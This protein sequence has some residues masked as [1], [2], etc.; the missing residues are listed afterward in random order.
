MRLHPRRKDTRGSQWVSPEDHAR[1]RSLESVPGKTV[2]Q[3]T[4]RQSVHLIACTDELPAR[5]GRGLRPVT[6][7]LN[8]TDIVE[9]VWRSSTHCNAGMMRERDGHP[10]QMPPSQSRVQAQSPADHTRSGAQRSRGPPWPPGVAQTASL[11]D[12]RQAYLFHARI[13]ICSRTRR[14]RAGSCSRDRWQLCAEEEGVFL[15]RDEFEA[16]FFVRMNNTGAQRMWSVADIDE[17]D[18]I[19]AVSGFSYLPARI[20]RNPGP[21]TD[22][23]SE[24]P[25]LPPAAPRGHRQNK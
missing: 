18:L 22:W 24:Q 3:V 6:R 1:G 5:N 8:L 13:Q 19:D 4:S 14:K 23:L 7:R 20:P 17:Q 12:D 11:A 16:G 21:L 2:G 9:A 15:C 25:A 10:V